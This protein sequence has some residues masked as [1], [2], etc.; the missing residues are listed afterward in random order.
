[1]YLFIEH[2]YTGLAS[3]NKYS[4]LRPVEPSKMGKHEGK[5]MNPYMFFANGTYQI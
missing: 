1:M 5:Y 2:L 4:P 3:Y